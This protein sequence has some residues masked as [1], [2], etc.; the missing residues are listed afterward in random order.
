WFTHLKRASHLLIVSEGKLQAELDLPRIGERASNC[1]VS[2]DPPAQNVKELDTLLKSSRSVKV[3]V[4]EQIER[5]GTELDAL[6]FQE[7]DV[8][9]KRKIE[10]R[11]ARADHRIAPQV[12]IGSGFRQSKRTRI[13]VHF[14]SSQL[15]ARG[16]AWAA[17]GNTFD[18]VVAKARKQIR[19]I[20]YL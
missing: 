20:C 3:R 18:R 16:N 9:H 10:V 7:R 15:R 8:F 5:L 12:A 17:L 11:Q 4:V 19:T 2:D 1:G 14:G 6:V 13:E